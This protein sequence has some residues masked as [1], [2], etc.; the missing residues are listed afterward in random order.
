M[1]ELIKKKKK[2]KGTSNTKNVSS[3]PGFLTPEIEVCRLHGH[4]LDWDF[5]DRNESA[6]SEVQRDGRVDLCGSGLRH[7][8]LPS[9]HKKQSRPLG[10]NVEIIS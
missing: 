7:S 4:L 3:D 1:K 10:K 2:N 6:V 9:F 5:G 8:V